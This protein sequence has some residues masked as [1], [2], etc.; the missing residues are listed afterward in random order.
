[1]YDEPGN[2]EEAIKYCEK[3]GILRE[4][5]KRRATE[6]LGMLFT[7]FNLEDAIAEGSTPEFAH[8]IADLT[9]SLGVTM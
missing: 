7:E 2:R 1:M 8:E 5:P 6:V 4:F 3:H 9:V